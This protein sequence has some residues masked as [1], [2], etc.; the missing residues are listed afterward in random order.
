M[1][2]A[3]RRQVRAAAIS[4]GKLV[5]VD[6]GAGEVE[7]A[8]VVG[9][10]EVRDAVVAHATGEGEQVLDLSRAGGRARATLEPSL[11]QVGVASD[12]GALEN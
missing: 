2:C 9:V 10:R 1:P 5:A 6:P 4:A 7:T 12:Q 3:T 11:F 8:L